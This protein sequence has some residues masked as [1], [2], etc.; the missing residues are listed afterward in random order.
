M[1]L[2]KDDAEL[3]ELPETKQR[4]PAPT[5]QPTASETADR[6]GSWD[7]QEMRPPSNI[8]KD[9][10]IV[11]FQVRSLSIS[12]ASPCQSNE[13]QTMQCNSKGYVS[14]AEKFTTEPGLV[15]IF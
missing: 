11:D 12:P 1:T 9:S 10:L 5:E 3:P 4:V 8:G 13:L 14:Q 2:D 7:N 6:P 15:S